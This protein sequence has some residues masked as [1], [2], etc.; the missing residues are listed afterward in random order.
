MW[1][2]TAARCSLIVSLDMLLKTIA[3][4]PPSVIQ[5]VHDAFTCVCVCVCI[6]S[7]WCPLPLCPQVCVCVCARIDCFW[8]HLF[9]VG[10]LEKNF[11][12]HF[13][14]LLSAL[15][16]HNAFQYRREIDKLIAAGGR[17]NT[18]HTRKQTKTVLSLLLFALSCW[19]SSADPL[20]LFPWSIKQKRMST[21]CVCWLIEFTRWLFKRTPHCSITYMK[22]HR[23][24][25]T[26]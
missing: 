9:R 22:N 6:I 18:V 26:H 1:R 21:S 13:S 23:G 11:A 17:K 14:G 5:D 16:S 20:T 2:Q 25:K 24:G 19:C 12:F 7:P 15:L 8:Q 10:H 4:P 3:A